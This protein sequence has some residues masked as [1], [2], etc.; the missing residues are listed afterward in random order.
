M[1]NPCAKKANNT[2][3]SD[4]AQ[5]QTPLQLYLDQRKGHRASPSP[6]SLITMAKAAADLTDSMNNL[7]MVKESPQKNGQESRRS[8]RTY[9]DA[10]KDATRS[11]AE[12]SAKISLRDDNIR[13]IAKEAVPSKTLPAAEIYS[14]HRSGKELANAANG[15][16]E[17]ITALND[18]A[19]RSV[20]RKLRSLGRESIAGASETR[21]LMDKMFSHFKIQI[22]KII[23]DLLDT[24]SEQILLWKVAEECYNEAA[25]DLGTLHAS[26]YFESWEFS[27]LEFE[28]QAR[29]EEGR[30]WV[31]YWM[32]ILSNAPNG[33][34]LFYPPTSS[35]SDRLRFEDV[36]Q[37]L[38]R[39]SDATILGDDNVITSIASNTNPKEDIQKDL[40]LLENDHAAKVLHSQLSKYCFGSRVS[41]N[42][43]SWT[44]SLLFAI[45][46]AVYRQ[47]YRQCDASKI[48][49]C[50]VDTTKFP[51]GQFARDTWLIE[52]YKSDYWQQ[53]DVQ[54]FFKF[55]LGFDEYYNGE[56]LS[57][58]V[59]NIA[60]RSCMM[61]LQELAKAGLFKLY[62]EF[63][64][65]EGKEKLA[66]RAIELRRVWSEERGTS[67]EEITLALRVAHKCF[68]QFPPAEIATA[69]L[70]LQD[71]KLSGKQPILEFLQHEVYYGRLTSSRNP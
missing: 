33:P 31:D 53:D 18:A 4:E 38:F 6:N 14:L 13:Q 54:K 3:W 43:V 49:I 62:P 68:P 7:Q 70:A 69:L 30:S 16:S 59:L 23:H 55:R 2:A 47:Q 40:L 5:T 57:Q 67:E 32:A 39:T 20:I 37:Y 22:R 9:V 10:L 52:A 36:P 50:A 56:Y 29:T 35:N 41:T 25:S 1:T 63:T 58:G 8:K 48:K 51:R 65:K 28:S 42:L 71:R 44:S 66:N 26:R 15:L 45:Q 60:N 61:S 12:A 11:L 19:Q 64:D 17:S 27:K 46:Y 21:T 34:T 24:T